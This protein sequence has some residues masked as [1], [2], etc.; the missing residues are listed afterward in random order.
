MVTTAAVAE[1]ALGVEYAVDGERVCQSL[2]LPSG[3]RE[4]WMPFSG[5]PGSDLRGLWW[6]SYLQGER[7]R[8]T[9]QD[10]RPLRV[11][12][13]FCG[14][15]GLALGLRQ[16]CDELG[17]AVESAIAADQD[18]AA[19]AVHRKNHRDRVGWDGSISMLVDYQVRGRAS[20]A[21]FRYP[22]SVLDDAWSSL[23]GRVDVLLAAPPC[24]G[25]STLNY[26]RGKPD[27]RTRN[28]G[29][30][31]NDLYLTAPAIAVALRAR[32]VIIENVPAAQWDE[33]DVV[34]STVQLLTDAG[35]HVDSG[36]LSADA[37]GWPQSRS[38]F[39]MVARLGV[40]PLPLAGVAESL[41]SEAR[42]ITWA[43]EDLVD[44]TDR[45]HMT[46][47]PSF[48]EENVERI[49][50]LF[51]NDAYDLPNEQRPDCHKDGTTYNAVYG[52]L[53]P[54]RPAPTITTGFMTPGRGRFIHPTR[55]RVLTAREAARL[56]GFPDDYDF[57]PD[58]S[59]PSKAQLAKWIGDAV[60][61]P[62]GYAAAMSVLAPGH[63]RDDN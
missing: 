18:V 58:G 62:L 7:P 13:L 21:R 53:H 49:R 27:G 2:H 31:R 19:L 56:Q 29:D 8:S 37:L 17:I 12:E 61:M 59:E 48:S 10:P 34:A 22:P 40:E 55:Q 28:K 44:E 16:A 6:K 36:T 57:K 63:P 5:D 35:Y 46:R 38:R 4:S 30:G 15:G 42:P 25:H 41:R 23:V 54:D 3:H 47:L 32:T 51:E 11:V 1:G 39:L 52:R 45:C 20:S 43:I 50:W 9:A 24:T 14:P 60:P 33:R 26:N